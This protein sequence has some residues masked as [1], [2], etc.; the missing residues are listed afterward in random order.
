MLIYSRY[1]QPA[2][3]ECN[4]EVIGD[5]LET[6]GIAVMDVEEG[7]VDDCQGSLGDVSCTPPA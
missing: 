6:V 2:K 5:V 1:V 3:A 7:A 4:P